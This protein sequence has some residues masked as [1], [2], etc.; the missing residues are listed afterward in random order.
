MEVVGTCGSRA[1]TS[2]TIRGEFVNK[3]YIIFISSKHLQTFQSA[4]SIISHGQLFCLF[5]SG[6]VHCMP[7]GWMFMSLY[8]MKQ[9]LKITGNKALLISRI[10]MNL[11]EYYTVLSG[12]PPQDQIP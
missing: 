6:S 1:S 8:D 11:N 12:F 5:R 2:S 3:E 10:R 4:V 9:V 7:R